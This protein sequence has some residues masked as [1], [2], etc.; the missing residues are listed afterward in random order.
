ML[1]YQTAS[2]MVHKLTPCFPGIE[3]LNNTT[4]WQI[5]RLQCPSFKIVMSSNV[6][7]DFARCEG[8]DHKFIKP[9]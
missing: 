5:N 7:E 1:Q 9:I 8:I 6:F 3:D 4:V 2:I